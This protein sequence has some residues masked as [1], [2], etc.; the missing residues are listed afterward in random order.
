[1]KGSKST[2]SEN[3]LFYVVFSVGRHYSKFLEAELQSFQVVK[4]RLKNL[5]TY[6][7]LFEIRNI[8][9]PK[10]KFSRLKG[11]SDVAKA[12]FWTGGGTFLKMATK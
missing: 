2:S 1:M 12:L 11:S 6:C 7:K 8:E 10:F 3:E 4:D 9:E 5:E